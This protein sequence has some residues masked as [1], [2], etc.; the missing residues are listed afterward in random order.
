VTIEW[1]TARGESLRLLAQRGAAPRL[2]WAPSLAAGLR[3]AQARQVP[4][5]VVLLG[6][7][8]EL[9]AP[10][11]DPT[12]LAALNE[13][14]VAVLGQKRDKEEK[15]KRSD[16]RRILTHEQVEVDGQV[17]CARESQLTCDQH[18]DV[19]KR[20]KSEDPSERV[21]P[22][23]ALELADKED[24]RLLFVL[25]TGA[26]A[27]ALSDEP[28][29]TG[30]PGIDA[31]NL[32]RAL[33]EARAGAGAPALP[34]DELKKLGEAQA[35]AHEVKDVSRAVGAYRKLARD[36]R[37]TDLV[38]RFAEHQLGDGLVAR[39]DALIARIMKDSASARRELRA[40]RGE[41]R[42]LPRCVERIEAALLVLD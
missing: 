9:P 8:D 3:E 26:R 24:C 29:R 28:E 19:Q 33:I 20:L 22:G 31:T 38:R 37:A 6:F 18:H 14:V 36:R 5:L 10:L 27:A 12:L 16:E 15:D 39:V 35:W 21:I 30:L 25:P 42:D 13:H 34:F 7:G 11:R 41:V 2:T 4:L 23:D 1:L 32:T 17:R 40:L